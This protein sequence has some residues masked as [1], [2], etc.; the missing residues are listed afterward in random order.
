MRFTK[1]R[2][3]IEYTAYNKL[4]RYTTHFTKKY[5]F[6]AENYKKWRLFFYVVMR[7]KLDFGVYLIVAG[8]RVRAQCASRKIE[9]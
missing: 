2:E 4:R 9:K 8:K 1:Q 3:E 7:L 5:I 6:A